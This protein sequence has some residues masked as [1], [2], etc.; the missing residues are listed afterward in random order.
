MV[1]TMNIIFEY[2]KCA[3]TRLNID[4]VDDMVEMMN[5]EKISS[6]LSVRK[7]TITREAEIEWIITHQDD[8]L[9]SVYDRTTSEYIGNCGFNDIDEG[10]GEIG[11]NICE[12]MQGKH[13]AKDIISGLVEYGYNKLGLDEIYGIIFSDNIRSLNCVKQ[14]GF[15]EYARDKGIFERNGTLIDDVYFKI[16]KLSNQ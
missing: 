5:N 14:L 3:F 1:E 4:N 6:M 7:R 15:D 8:N 11:L 2:G 12:H 9:F 13:Y 10:R 16:S